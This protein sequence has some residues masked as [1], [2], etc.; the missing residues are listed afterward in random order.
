MEH[1]LYIL[2][3]YGSLLSSVRVVEGHLTHI[4]YYY[5][6]IIRICFQMPQL[7]III[8]IRRGVR[9]LPC[10]SSS[11]V[12]LHSS[13]SLQWITG[14]GE[15]D[16]EDHFI[17]KFNRK[18]SSHISFTNPPRKERELLFVRGKWINSGV[19]GGAGAC[20]IAAA[21]QMKDRSDTAIKL[22]LHLMSFV[23]YEK[24]THTDLYF[25]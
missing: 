10:S 4:T 14:S 6:Y 1:V 19:V 21:G 25:V 18:S 16:E 13:L 24:C 7:H 12:K 23:N 15:E 2:R 5:Y 22:Q 9:K 11:S 3:R 17:I 8:V 20:N